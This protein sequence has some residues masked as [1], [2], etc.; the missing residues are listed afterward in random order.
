MTSC[1]VV[2]NTA[3]H[4]PVHVET[5][6]ASPLIVDL[7][8]SPTKISYSYA[9]I[10][11]S[12]ASL[13]KENIINTAVKQ[14]LLEN[15]NADVMVGLETQIQYSKIG[16]ESVIITGYPAKYVNFRHVDDDLWVTKDIIQMDQQNVNNVN[17]VILQINK[18]CLNV[19]Y[20]KQE[21]Y[22]RKLAHC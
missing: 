18:E 10:P 17:Q 4:K 1:T 12:I 21:Q 22:L 7:D 16:I 3:T 6:I 15:G 19:Q 14:A 13:G 8:V 20:V 2:L 9:P 11:A 5:P